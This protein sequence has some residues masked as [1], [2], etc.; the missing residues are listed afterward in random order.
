MSEIPDD[1]MT[2]A[3]KLVDLTIRNY[4]K[5][6]F[7]NV[8]RD[9]VAAAIFAERQ[10]CADT[11]RRYMEDIAGCDMNDDEPDKIAAAIMDPH[12]APTPL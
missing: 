3:G 8:S 5:E 9:H 4:E 12:W 2:A 11:A 1:I 6:V 7:A 10:R